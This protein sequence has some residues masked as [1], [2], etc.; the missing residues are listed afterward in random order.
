VVLSLLV[1]F[2][3]TFAFTF[4]LCQSVIALIAVLAENTW[5]AFSPLITIRILVRLQVPGA[6]IFRR[7]DWRMGGS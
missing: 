1:V 5:A 6:G 7:H 3:F 4:R 2:V